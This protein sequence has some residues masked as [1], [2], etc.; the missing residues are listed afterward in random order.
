LGISVSPIADI[1][2]S[3]GASMSGS[4]H[5]LVEQWFLTHQASESGSSNSEAW[6]L[7]QLI[8]FPADPQEV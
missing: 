5:V 8:Q 4:F 1:A 7:L 6:A 3:C 2:S